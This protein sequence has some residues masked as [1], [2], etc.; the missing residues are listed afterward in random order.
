MTDKP[1]PIVIKPKPVDGGVAVPPPKPTPKNYDP[2]W[3]EKQ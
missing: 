3:R 1:A 2:D